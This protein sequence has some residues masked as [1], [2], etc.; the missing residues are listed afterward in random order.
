MCCKD[1]RLATTE[2]DV[3]R[4]AA[5]PTMP[6]ATTCQGH[7]AARLGGWEDTALNVSARLTTVSQLNVHVMT[8]TVEAA[9]AAL[10]IQSRQFSVVTKSAV[11]GQN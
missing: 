4:D 3:S 5:A 2:L 9:T 11:Q 10:V 1:V 6:H 7:V 8:V